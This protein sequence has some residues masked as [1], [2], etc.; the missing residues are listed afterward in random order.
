MLSERLGSPSGQ[1]SPASGALVSCAALFE[2]LLPSAG[3]PAAVQILGEGADGTSPAVAIYEEALAAAPVE[4][5][6]MSMHPCWPRG[7]D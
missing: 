2:Q 6:T 1:L 5:T 7:W 3:G 4:V